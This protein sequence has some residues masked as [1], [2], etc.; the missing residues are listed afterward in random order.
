MIDNQERNFQVFKMERIYYGDN[1][2]V[3]LSNLEDY[4]QFI[5]MATRYISNALEVCM[6]QSK[7]RIVLLTSC[8][9]EAYILISQL[10]QQLIENI[11][12]STIME[13][14]TRYIQDSVICSSQMCGSSNSRIQDAQNLLQE[15]SFN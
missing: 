1:N 9:Q 8:L 2:H 3:I 11:F 10:N 15:E 6:K 7:L 5:V 4:F 12:D 13:F 14:T